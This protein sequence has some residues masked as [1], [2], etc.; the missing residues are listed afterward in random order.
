MGFMVK[1]ERINS[2]IRERGIKKTWLADRCDISPSGL[3]HYLHGRSEMTVE[4]AKKLAVALGV[5]LDEIVEFT[6]KE[7]VK[8]AG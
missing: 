2:L 6:T 5:R 8:A 3:G 7:D 1:I 4:F